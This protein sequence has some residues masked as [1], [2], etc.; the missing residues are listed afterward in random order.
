MRKKK[1]ND[2]ITL[3]NGVKVP[4]L[5]LGTWMIDDDK[6]KEV[7][8]NAFKLGY[9][10]IDTA[11]AYGN[12]RGV[13]EAIRESGLKR[14]DYYLETKLGPTLYENDHAIDDTL[15]RLGVDYIDV[16]ILHHPVNN[17][18]YAYKMLEKAY[19]EGKIKAIGLSNFQVSQIQEIMDQ[20]EIPPMIMQVECH[21]YYP[22]E[23]VYDFCKKNHIQLQSW[24]P[25]GHGNSEM[26]KEAIFV[27]LAKK[28][29][30]STVQI[31]LRWHLQMGFGLVP[32]SKSLD[33]IEANAQ[34]FDF[35]LTDEEM[36]EI[37]KVN[38][39]TQF[40]KVTKEALQRLATTKC[41]F[42]EGE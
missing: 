21:P 39:H 2:K 1:I 32:G 7:V 40:Y 14:E 8:L 22:A 42:E 37:E 11:E 27:E 19:K 28:Y 4:V 12:E 18:I 17:Y 20:C 16:M 35:E 3:Y 29:H 24:Y 31:I 5:G 26:L 36:K 41:N 23:H 15:K 34:I 25:L 33:H 30:K 9:R 13:G 38:K 10:H 6:V